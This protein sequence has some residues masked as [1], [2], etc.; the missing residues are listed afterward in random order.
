VESPQL[1]VPFIKGYGATSHLQEK[2]SAMARLATQARFLVLVALFGPAFAPQRLLAEEKPLRQIIDAEIRAAWKR[3]RIKPA[4]R[5]DD[6]TFLRR[7]YLDLAGTIPS[8]DDALRFLD[9]K[10]PKK[11]E[12]LIDRLLD[13]PRFA[14][15]QA[16]LWDQL[17]FGRD[18]PNGDATRKRDSFKKWLTDKF[19]KN[20]PYDRWVRDLLLAEQEGSALFYVQYRNQPA[21]AAV[22]VSRIFLGM[23]LQCARCHDHPY[24]KW[25]QRDFYGL[26][27]FFVRL[28]VLDT[29]GPP[30]KRRFTIA[31][32]STGEVLFTGP[33]KEQKPGQKGEPVKAKFLGGTE[34]EEPP[35]PKDFKEPQ[36]K[37]GT[38]PPKPLFSR[39]LKLA[40]WVTDAKNPYFAR[41]A[42]NRVWA[43]F[44]GR[45]LVDPVDDLSDK[46]PSRLAGL[47]KTLT[48]QLLAH[49]F[50]LKWLIRELV[51]SETYQLASTGETTEAMPVW[52]ERARVR[53]LSAEE[54]LTAVPTAT[55]FFASATKLGEK[56]PGDLVA[57]VERYFGEPTDGQ[58]RFQASLG[59]HLFSNNSEQL[60]RLIQQRKGNLADQLMISKAPWEARVDR[61]FLSVLSRPPRPEERKRFVAHLT[62]KARP[63]T[64]VEEA[65]WALLSCSE[66]RF[67]H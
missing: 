65:I 8:H 7:V 64:L 23:Q 41:A 13:D 22:A 29:G 48:E 25:T 11:R 45:G 40:E 6:A 37:P 66:F 59:E 15:Q 54:I 31:E 3:E 24:E 33:V 56:L 60:R 58:G 4:P 27:G 19:A 53:P 9:D 36:L 51:N 12:K 28:Q 10:D 14:V 2:E 17:L 20:E 63:E 39:K 16:N 1:L 50:D 35:G 46:N 57:Y 67:N 38:T 34:L 32:K 43:Q 42:A 55:G 18:P 21:D 49:Q 52:F 5:A 62:S 30:D 26:A 61:L 44:M 47:L